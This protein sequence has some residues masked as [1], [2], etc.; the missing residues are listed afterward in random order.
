MSPTSQI[1][2]VA[3]DEARSVMTDPTIEY[4][5]QPVSGQRYEV[6]IE[7]PQPPP[8]APPPGPQT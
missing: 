3:G 5:P 7:A 8:T 2:I 6:D 1:H 4:K